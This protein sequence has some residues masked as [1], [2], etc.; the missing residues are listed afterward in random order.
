MFMDV[1]LCTM[2][3]TGAHRSQKRVLDALE[4]VLQ[5]V[6]DGCEPPCEWWDSNPGPLESL[7]VLLTTKPTL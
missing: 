6:T 1:C 3:M 2:Y 7:S 4:L 5:M